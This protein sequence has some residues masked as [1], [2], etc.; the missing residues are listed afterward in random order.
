MSSWDPDLVDLVRAAGS[1]ASAEHLERLTD[2]V[3]EFIV[4]RPDYAK[5]ARRMGDVFHLT[6]RDAEAAYVGAVFIE[7]IVAALAALEGQATAEAVGRRLRRGE[8]LRGWA[9]A[10][11]RAR[12]RADVSA[13]IRADARLAV[14]D[15]AERAL[16]AVP[17]IRSY[18]ESVAATPGVGRPSAETPDA[19]DPAAP[20]RDGTGER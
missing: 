16:R 10:A 6:G 5:A 2:E 7:L 17:S 19:G 20:T 13:P 15:Y 3:Y 18:L 9:G 1:H 8:A 11:W 12:N 14:S 4:T